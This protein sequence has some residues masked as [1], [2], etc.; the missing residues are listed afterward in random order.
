LVRL[1]ENIDKQRFDVAV[2]SLKNDG[3]YGQY[4]RGIGVNVM[5]LELH[6]A[7]K[8]KMFF[9]LI[10][11]IKKMKP[12][13]IQTWMYHADFIG[14]FLGRLAGVKNIVWNIRSTK[15]NFKD[16]SWHAVII[17]KMCAALSF[18]PKKIINCSQI[19]IEEHIKVGYKKNKFVYIPNGYDLSQ[20]YFD[21]AKSALKENN[22]L[23]IGIVGRNNPQ[24]DFLNFFSALKIIAKESFASELKVIVVGRGFPKDCSKMIEDLYPVELNFWGEHS[25][26]LAVYN[27]FDF[28]VLSSKSEAFP[29]VIAEAMACGK[30]CVA[31]DVGDA[32]I[33]V[34]DTGIVVAPSNSYELAQ[35]I[36]K[37]VLLG[38][39]DIKKLGFKARRQIEGH[40]SLSVMIDKYERLY[41]EICGVIPSCAE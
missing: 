22:M 38:K 39:A 18:L 7:S 25:D 35:G 36:K 8:I 27:S 29:N 28:L 26:M 30:P 17:R 6:R 2:I 15:L 9:Q 24:K 4:L 37:M 31:T 14:L 16:S 20:L 33:I 34:G 41:N 11:L 19:S 13:V 12:D 10:Y 1:I 5:C 23:T 32:R 21:E 40:Y 3:I